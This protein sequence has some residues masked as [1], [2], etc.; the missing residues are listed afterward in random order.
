MKFDISCE[1]SARQTIYMRCQILFSLQ[2]IKFKKKYY[3]QGKYSL[4]FVNVKPFFSLKN[5]KVKQ[6]KKKQS[7]TVLLGSSRID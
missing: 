1:L 5:N 7:S 3:F 6:S 4:T 2:D